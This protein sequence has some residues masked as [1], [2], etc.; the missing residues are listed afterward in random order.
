MLTIIISGVIVGAALFVAVLSTRLWL[1][2]RGNRRFKRAHDLL[3]EEKATF[4]DQIEAIR[5]RADHDAFI[6]M[7]NE[8]HAR[9]MANLDSHKRHLDKFP[10]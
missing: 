2:G 7:I 3:M 1:W 6:A 8:W 9:A 4:D 5:T 10:W